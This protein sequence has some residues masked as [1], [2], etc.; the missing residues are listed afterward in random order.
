MKALA[1][2]LTA[3]SS[4]LSIASIEPVYHAGALCVELADRDGHSENPFPVRSFEK[5]PFNLRQVT[6]RVTRLEMQQK[7]Q[8]ALKPLVD[9]WRKSQL[10]GQPPQDANGPAPMEVD[11]EVQLIR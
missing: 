3:P 9:E 1:G 6:E 7:I 10:Q 11:Q 2:A 4:P 8:D 5:S